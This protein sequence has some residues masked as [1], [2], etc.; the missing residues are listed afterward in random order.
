MSI[1]DL[2]SEV[3][4]TGTC[5]LHCRCKCKL[6][7]EWDRL[8]SHKLSYVSLLWRTRRPRSHSAIDD[9]NNR[10]GILL[11]PGR[12]RCSVSTVHDCSVRLA[13][14]AGQI[15]PCAAA[16]MTPIVRIWRNRYILQSKQQASAADLRSEAQL[17]RLLT[18][19]QNAHSRQF[20]SFPKLSMTQM[21][22]PLQIAASS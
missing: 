2:P 17:L 21:L 3:R 12:P 6:L 4:L 13:V 7:N 15:Q 20:E 9:G 18:V 11:F 22:L 16:L 1:H 19:V 8:R 10:V 5:S 14:P